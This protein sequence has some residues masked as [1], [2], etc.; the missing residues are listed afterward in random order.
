M[1]DVPLTFARPI[2][3]RRRRLAVVASATGL[4]IA[5]L[6]IALFVRTLMY[7]GEAMPGV[8]L[9]GAG[10]AGQSRGKLDRTILSIAGERLVRPITLELGSRSLAVAPPTLL[11]VDVRA[12]AAAALRAGQSSFFARAATLLS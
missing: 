1:T 12:T 5:G 7:R 10:L 6:A 2:R 9:L 3:R 4:V 8:R 11:A